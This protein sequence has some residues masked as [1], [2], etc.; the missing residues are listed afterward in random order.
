MRTHKSPPIFLLRHDCLARTGRD[1]GTKLSQHKDV[2]SEVMRYKQSGRARL[3]NGWGFSFGSVFFGSSKK[4]AISDCKTRFGSENANN[5]I[6]NTFIRAEI[7]YCF[8][9]LETKTYT[10]IP[11]DFLAKA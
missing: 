9:K 8:K 2:L 6:W 3:K 7:I 11:S 5:Q 4:V 10:Q 1:A